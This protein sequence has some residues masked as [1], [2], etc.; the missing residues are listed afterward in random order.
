L[1][2]NKIGAKKMKMEMNVEKLRKMPKK[3]IDKMIN[4]GLA[5]V[6]VMLADYNETTPQQRKD[7]LKYAEVFR[8]LGRIHGVKL[9]KPK[10]EVIYMAKRLTEAEREDKEI[11]KIMLRIRSLEK[12]YPQRLVERACFRYKNANLEKRNTEKEMKV[13]EKRLEEA[14]RRLK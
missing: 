9:D 5:D 8:K 3:K 11:K 14:K 6:C 12:T 4:E 13:L 1:E 10:R 2:D 7:F